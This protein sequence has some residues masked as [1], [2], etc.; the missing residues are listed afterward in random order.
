MLNRFDRIEWS[1]KPKRSF[2]VLCA[3]SS[4]AVRI[5]AKSNS[6][7]SAEINSPRRP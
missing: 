1:A 2:Q 5:H 7:V 6:I 4:R 3:G